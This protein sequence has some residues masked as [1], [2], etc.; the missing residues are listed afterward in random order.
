MLRRETIDEQV[1][2]ERAAVCHQPGVLRLADLE[3]RRIVGRDALNR[4]QGVLAGDFDLAHVAHVEQPGSFA[5]RQML[6]DD[7]RVFDGHVP[8]AK[9]HHPG[10]GGA[11]TS[12]ERRLLERRGGSLFHSALVSCGLNK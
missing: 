7:A 12:V 11:V 10:A 4:G 6:G 5:N 3:L 9:G 2:H 1:V 8:A